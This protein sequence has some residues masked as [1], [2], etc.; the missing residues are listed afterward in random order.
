VWVHVIGLKEL[1]KGAEI[2]VKEG[3]VAAAKTG[4]PMVLRY[5]SESMVPGM[6]IITLVKT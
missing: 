5:P 4:D 6:A 3:R 2:G 1:G